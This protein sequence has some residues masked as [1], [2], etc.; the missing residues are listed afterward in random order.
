MTKKKYAVWIEE[1]GRWA[2][3]LKTEKSIE[4]TDDEF[5]ALFKGQELGKQ[6]V[7]GEDGRPKLA[8]ANSDSTYIVNSERSWRDKELS[9][10]D[11]EIYKV[12]DSDTNSTG[13]ISQWREYR[14]ALRAWP[15][16][17]DFPNKD[18]RPKAPDA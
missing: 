3:G 1:D 14:K 10:T 8:T 16:H 11:I 13:T 12:Q 18:S 15:Q 7:K 17:K 5:T 9:R 4:L 6:I 2:F